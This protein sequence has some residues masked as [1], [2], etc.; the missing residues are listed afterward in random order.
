MKLYIDPGT[1]S[2]LFS[3]AIGLLSCLWFGLQKAYM[4]VKYLTLG[5][6]K[7][8]STK[9]DIVIYS[10]DKRYWTSFKSICDELEKRKTKILYLAG[11]ED[12]PILKENYQYIERK[13]IG[14]GN[15]AFAQLNFLNCRVCLATTPGLDVYQW[16]RSKNV[17][18]YV[19]MTHSI[20]AGTAYKMFGTQFF[21]ALLLS[22]ED[23]IPI[24]RVLESKRESKPKEIVAVGQTYMD[25][26]LER[27]KKL[28]SSSHENIRVLLAPSW[29]GN[30]LLN[31]WGDKI[32]DAL[33]KS[34]LDIT[35]RPHPQSFYSET[36][37][38]KHLQSKYPETERF[39]WNTDPDN[40]QVLSNADI[41]I[42]DFSGVIYDFSFIF[43][44]PIMYTGVS[45]DL[46]ATDHAWID[47]PLWIYSLLPQLGV[48]LKEADFDNIGDI[49]K[50]LVSSDKYSKS[51]KAA[52]DKY[53]QHIGC[54]SEGVAEYL[55][56]KNE[57]LKQNNA[58]GV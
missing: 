45:L 31:K 25:Y 35:I 24:H 3:L 22:S 37:L 51:I 15:K 56:G 29:G 4:K 14:L 49:I 55:L 28:T 40:F 27:K 7:S 30:S 46:S 18:F 26:L 43:E 52:R 2:M 48:E 57:L 5:S 32:V 47:E 16:K 6:E 11:S 1:G 23:F 54:A 42:S 34:G 44:R 9:R 17:D 50:Q 20:G 41:L 39:H 19:H 10:E 36:E 12:D 21:D 53:W 13:V 33:I 58:P 38:I 8:D